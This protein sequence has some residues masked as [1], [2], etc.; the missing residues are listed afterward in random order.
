[1]N[2]TLVFAA[3]VALAACEKA[4][5]TK[6]AG[7]DGGIQACF[8]ACGVGC[9]APQYWVCGQSGDRYCNSCIAGCHSDPVVTCPQSDAGVADGGQLLACL[10]ACGVGCPAPQYWVCGQSG[11]RYCNSCIAACYADPI[12]DCNG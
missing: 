9:P 2:R 3:V 1:M 5:D 8:D 11:E 4:P 12:V 10:T 6:D 7:T